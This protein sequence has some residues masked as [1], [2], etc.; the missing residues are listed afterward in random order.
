MLS[1]RLASIS[2]ERRYRQLLAVGEKLTQP[3]P[4]TFS[5]GLLVW[6]IGR[7]LTVVSLSDVWPMTN[8]CPPVSGFG[9]PFSDLH[10]LGWGRILLLLPC[11]LLR[12]I[13][14]SAAWVACE[15]G[16][17]D[18]K[19]PAE[20]SWSRSEMAQIKQKKIGSTRSNQT[21]IVSFLAHN[22]PHVFLVHRTAG[23]GWSLSWNAGTQF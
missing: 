6:R 12:E 18:R 20:L 21:P 13:E 1:D 11:F 7:L 8:S 19:I 4:A 22:T 2:E 23:C 15:P 10:K 16:S 5:N 9:K 17:R 3:P 14:L